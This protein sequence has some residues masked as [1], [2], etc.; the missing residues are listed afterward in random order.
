MEILLAV[1][2]LCLA[3]IEIPWLKRPIERVVRTLRDRAIVGRALQDTLPAVR[4]I[5]AGLRRRF[6]RDCMMCQWDHLITVD[7]GGSTETIIDS[8]VV[9]I[10]DREMATIAFPVYFDSVPDQLPAWAKIGRSPLHL[11]L[12]QWDQ[13]TG[14]GLVT[15]QFTTPL[16]PREHVRLKWGY[17]NPRSFSEGNE[18][19]EWFIGRPHS[20]LKVRLAFDEAWSLSALRGIIVPEDHAPQAPTLRGNQ[21]TWSVPAPMP[22]HKY[23][24]EFALERQE[25]MADS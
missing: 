6:T 24:L 16:K 14:N 21:I 5:R 23:R 8:L 18:W 13:A 1:V 2:C 20:L 4:S 10:A 19:W 11:D 7:A 15:V 12:T 9:N 3:V 22:G 25:A 17:S